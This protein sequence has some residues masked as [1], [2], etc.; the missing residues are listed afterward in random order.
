MS[1][2]PNAILS[3]LYAGRKLRLTFSSMLAAENYRKALYRAKRKQDEA[4]RILIG[5]FPKT[6]MVDKVLGTQTSQTECSLILRLADKTKAIDFTIIDDPDPHDPDP[7]HLID[8][9]NEDGH[10]L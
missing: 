1:D 7:G 2:S 9:R 6:L 8:P 5:E 10:E 3:L 4:L